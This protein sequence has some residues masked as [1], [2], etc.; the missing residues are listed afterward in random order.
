MVRCFIGFL[1]PD[2][3]KEKIV[4]V[5][6][7]VKNLPIVCKLVEKENLHINFSFLGEVS[8]S[9]L[10]TLKDRLK[11][12]CS[13]VK[14][15]KASVDGVKLVPSESFI[16]VIVLDVV[17]EDLQRLLEKIK[18]E[19]GGSIKPLHITLCRVKKL[20]GSKESIVRKAKEMKFEKVDFYINSVCL[21]K[22]ELKRDGPVYTK[23]YESRLM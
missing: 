11:T 2:A 17:S 3:L 12:V 16:R 4:G 23:L 15:I 1:L 13:N 9:K 22:S 5:Q 19:V 6:E 10:E 8:E 7:K 20:E 14:T 21:I 18:D